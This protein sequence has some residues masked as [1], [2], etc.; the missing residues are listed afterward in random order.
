ME[1]KLSGPTRTA[2]DRSLRLEGAVNFRD[3]G[4]LTTYDGR[5]T[6]RG[7]LFRGDN[8]RYLTGTDTEFFE[9]IGLRTVIDLRSAAERRRDSSRPLA[10]CVPLMLHL[11]M[12]HAPGSDDSGTYAVPAGVS[13]LEDLYVAYLRHSGEGVAKIFSVLANPK[14]LPALFHCAAGKDRTG[15]MAALVLSSVGVEDDVIADDY[16]ATSANMPSLIAL[17]EIA[18]PTAGD[19][20]SQLDPELLRSDRRTIVSTLGWL[21]STYGSVEG[22]LRFCGV[23]D[24]DVIV[25]RHRLLS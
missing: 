21:R 9:R 11:A 5:V 13:S 24:E 25:L 23:A 7:I 12:Q 3:L 22:Y 14:T 17:L 20:L 18:D 15:L 4:G 16:E 19:H 2:E 6:A 8:P 10:S 1:T